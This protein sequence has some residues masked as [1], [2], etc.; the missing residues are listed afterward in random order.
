MQITETLFPIFFIIALGAVLRWRNFMD[1]A[2]ISGMNKLAFWVGLPC[3]LAL[4]I[5]KA[6][7]SI[8]AAGMKVLAVLLIVTGA[9]ML[10]AFVFA[11]IFRLPGAKAGPFIQGSFRGNWA[12]IG[13]V[14]I[15]FAFYAISEQAGK[16][17]M[18]TACIVL[19]PMVAVYNIAAV[20]I[21]L[22]GKHTMNRGA[23]KNMMIKLITNPLLIACIVGMIWNAFS[24][25]LPSIAQKTMKTIGEFALPV[26][27]LGVG[28]SMMQTRIKGIL[29][30]PAI[31]AGLLKTAVGPVIGYF[32]CMYFGLGDIDTMVVL[33]FLATPTAISSY[34]TADQLDC[35]SLMS[36][37]II[38]ISTFMSIVSLAVV[39]SMI[40]VAKPL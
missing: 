28:G 16:E 31:I 15:N 12:Y 9:I 37:E 21:L 10:I 40:N 33:I 1:D 3:L 8:D 5:A 17:A 24:L 18:D 30:N 4:N 20:L 7:R 38:V 34:T 2:L 25:P 19:A 39:L 29:M 13:L 32:V 6:N 11:L 35:D 14:V 26:A 27:L 23:V 36:A 22:L